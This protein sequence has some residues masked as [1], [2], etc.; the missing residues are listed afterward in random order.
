MKDRIPFWVLELA[1][2]VAKI[3][4][5]KKL[6]KPFYYPYKKR[7][8]NRRNR[9]FKRYAL[10]ALS[11]LDKCMLENKFNYTLTFGSLLG[12]IR[13]KGFISHDLDMDIMIPIEER[14]PLIEEVLKK[15]GFKL[16]HRFSI[17]D[18]AL[19][20]EEC[21]LYKDTGVSIDIF[22]IY[23]TIDNYPYLCC[24]NL[25]PG[26]ATWRESVKKH[27]GLI[28][29]RIEIPITYKTTRSKFESIEINI[30]ENYNDILKIFYGSNYMTP[31]PNYIPPKEHRYIWIEKIA[32]YEQF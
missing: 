19:G 17:D 18:G 7:I 4:Y 20:C 1:N 31:N 2:K 8:D 10:E 15:S 26:C 29:K 9:N 25:F 32:K 5:A 22:Y 27:G 14:T 11:I 12:A 28:P 16:S 6:I 24:W 23:P 13:E 3:P 30:P 21:Y